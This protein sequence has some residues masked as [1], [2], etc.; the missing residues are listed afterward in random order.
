MNKDHVQ[1]NIKVW[2][3]FHLKKGR[4]I[5]QIPE[6]LHDPNSFNKGYILDIGCGNGDQMKLFSEKDGFIS[7]GI[8][9]S[10][11]ALKEADTGLHVVHGDA[12]SLPFKDNI[13]ELVYSLGVIEHFPGTNKAIKESYRVA[14]H[15]GWV[16]HT[17]PN[18]FSIWSL[19]IKPL[20]KLFGKWEV[21]MEK[22]FSKAALGRKMIEAGFKDIGFRTYGFKDYSGYSG[23]VFMLPLKLVDDMLGKLFSKWGFFLHMWGRK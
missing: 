9:V 3:K 13:F 17:V 20:K 15:S 21:G 10:Y 7:I 23:S 5:S 4:V 16:F 12:E 2:D 14:A 11:S 22:S 8:D 1:E 18:R 19:V 6:F